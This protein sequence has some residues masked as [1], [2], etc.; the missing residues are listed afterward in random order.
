MRT[1]DLR[2]IPAFIVSLGLSLLGL[3]LGQESERRVKL[4]DLPQAVQKTVREQSRGAIVKGFSKEVEHGQTY[5]EVEMKVNGHGKDVLIDP[6]G[7][8]VEIE[9]E[10]ALSDLPPDVR[11]GIAQHAGKGKILKVESI[12]KGN[13]VVMY[14]A[15]VR[16]AGK[17]SEIKVGPDGKLAPQN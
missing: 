4:K 17:R 16:K 7:Q 6:T 14:E 1:W 2:I 5:Y 13:T 12:T 9:E 15:V 11:A 10:V 3:A 8:V